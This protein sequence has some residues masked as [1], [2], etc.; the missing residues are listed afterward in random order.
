MNQVSEQNRAGIFDGGQHSFEEDIPQTLIDTGT[1]ILVEGG[2]FNFPEWVQ[3]DKKIYT[4]SGKNLDV[5][6]QIFEIIGEQWDEKVTH[7]KSGDIII[8]IRSAFD[9]EVRTYTGTIIQII[10]AVNE[11]CGCKHVESGATMTNHETGTT[12]QMADGGMVAPNGKKSNLNE[13]Q[14]HLVRT[15]EFKKWFG[16]WENDPKNASKVVDENGE[17]LVVYHGISNLDKKFYLF[18]KKKIGTRWA[19]TSGVK[20]F[21]FSSNYL[22]ALTYAKSFKKELI[23]TC[24]LSIKNPSIYNANGR[25]WKQVKILKEPIQHTY[26]SNKKEDWVVHKNMFYTEAIPNPNF[27]KW[28]IWNK[29]TGHIL[30][31]YE[32]ESEAIS[33]FERIKKESPKKLLVREIGYSGGKYLDTNE[34]AEI[35]IREGND[36]MI[37]YNVVDYGSSIPQN[38]N[39]PFTLCAVFEPTQIKLADG[40]N[41]TFDQNNPDI[42]KVD[43]GQ[44][45]ELNSDG[46]YEYKDKEEKTAN[47]VGLITLPKNI[48]TTNCANCIFFKNNF[49][50]HEKIL[51]PV[52]SRM[53]CAL[54]DS[55]S[56]GSIISNLPSADFSPSKELKEKKY[57]LNDN[58]GFDYIGSGLKRAKKVDLITLPKN[59][60]GT[61]CAIGNCKYT[62]ENNFC[63][64]PK[65]MLPVTD[66]MSCSLWDNDEAMRSWKGGATEIFFEDGKVK[67]DWKATP[68]MKQQ[69]M[70]VGG[71]TTRS[72]VKGG[73]IAQGYIIAPYSKLKGI[74]GE[75]NVKNEKEKIGWY[76]AIDKNHIGAVWTEADK[77]VKTIMKEKYHKWFVWGANDESQRRLYEVLRSQ[78]RDID[79]EK[80]KVKD[81]AISIKRWIK[82]REHIQEISNNVHRLRLNIS[83][84]LNSDDERT[85]LIALI[86]AIMDKTAER[87]GNIKSAGKGHFGVT[88]FTKKHVEV[89]GNKIL[90]DYVG[91]TGVPH[92]KD[93]S[94]K[95]IA[96]A[97]KKAIKN[98]PNKIEGEPNDF[99]F[100]TSDGQKIN[101]KMV[102]DFLH[103]YQITS[104]AIRGYFANRNIIK[105]LESIPILE[106]DKE[107]KKIFNKALNETAKLVQHGRSTLKTHY[108]IPELM[109]EY[110]QR[111]KIIDMKK[112]GYYDKGGEAGMEEVTKHGSASLTTRMADGAQPEKKYFYV[113][114]E[115]EAEKKS[116]VFVPATSYF[117][118]ENKVPDVVNKEA[119][120]LVDYSNEKDINIHDVY[121]SFPLR[122][123]SFK[124]VVPMQDDLNAEKLENFINETASDTAIFPPAFAIEHE[125][126]YYL[127]DGHHRTVAFHINGKP[128][129]VHVDEIKEE[130]IR[131]KAEGGILDKENFNSEIKK[132]IGKKFIHNGKEYKIVD[133]QTGYG[134]PTLSIMDSEGNDF[135]HKEQSFEGRTIEK[136]FTVT[137]LRDLLNS[138]IEGGKIQNFTQFAVE[139]GYPSDFDTLFEAQ[140]LG[141]RGLEGK[142]QSTRS[143]TEQD[144]IFHEMLRKNKQAHEEYREAIARGEIIDPEGKITAQGMIDSEKKF[145]LDKIRSE[146]GI[147][148]NQ[149][150]FIESLG[151]MAHTSSGKLKKGY[152]RTVDDYAQ[153]KIKL[154]QEQEEVSKMNNGGQV[155]SFEEFSAD[156]DA[157]KQEVIDDMQLAIDKLKLKYDKLNQTSYYADEMAKA[158][159]M[160][161]VGFESKRLT[162]LR[163]RDLERTID[164]AVTSIQIKKDIQMLEN[165]MKAYKAGKVHAN[166]NPKVPSLEKLNGLI[167]SGEKMLESGEMKGQKMTQEEISH[168]EDI[169]SE[170]KKKRRDKEKKH[171]ALYEEYLKEQSKQLSTGGETNLGIGDYTNLG[172][173]EDEV[174]TQF[175]INGQWYHKSLVQPKKIS[176]KEKNKIDIERVINKLTRERGEGEIELYHGTD[177]DSYNK[178]ISDKQIGVGEG[179]TF[180]THS[181]KEAKEYADNKARYRNKPSGKVL[182]ITMPK[183]AVQKNKATGEYETEFE[184]QEKD[185]IWIP[186][187][188][189]IEQEYLKDNLAN[190]GITENTKT[191]DYTIG[192]AMAQYQINDLNI[193][194][195]FK[196]MIVKGFHNKFDIEKF[197]KEGSQKAHTIIFPK[198]W[199]TDKFL[200]KFKGSLLDTNSD[201]YTIDIPTNEY[202]RI[203]ELSSDLINKMKPLNIKL[204][205][206]GLTEEKQKEAERLAKEFMAGLSAE[207]LT[208]L[209]QEFTQ[210]L[211]RV[212]IE[213]EKTLTD[214]QQKKTDL[215]NERTELYAKEKTLE[216]GKEKDDSFRRRMQIS[217]EIEMLINPELIHQEN[218]VKAIKNGGDMASFTDKKG[219]KHDKIPSFVKIKTDLITF[220]Q[221]T[222]LT[223]AVPP[224]IPFINEQVFKGKGFVFDAIRIASDEYLVAV[225]GYKEKRRSGYDYRAGDFTGHPE[226]A[227]QGYILTT[228]DQ[229]ALINDYYFTKEKATLQKEADEKNIRYEQSYDRIPVERRIKYLVYGNLPVSEKKKITKED[230]EKLSVEEKEK[231]YKPF[232]RAGVKRLKSKLEENQMWVSYHNMYER[233]INPEAVSPKQGYANEE[234]FAYW[235]K[236]RQ[237]MEWKIKD[238]KVQR[239]A[240]S[241][242]RKIALETSF[243]ESNTNDSLK[244]KYGILVKRQNGTKIMPAEIDQ[245][246][247]AW[248]KLNKTFGNLVNNAKQV[249]LK[250]SH[251]GLKYVFASKAG[252]M[253]LPDMKTIAV[254]NKFGDDQ[255][256]EIFAHETAHWIDYSI[257]QLKGKRYATDD[258]ESTA[259]IIADTLRHE[260]NEPSDSDYVNATKECFARAMEQYFAFENFGEDATLIYSG[261]ALDEYRTY[262]SEDKYVS[263]EVFNSKLKPLIQ[264]FLAE[265]E[266]WFNYGIEPEV[267]M[268]NG[269]GTPK[270]IL[271]MP[272]DGRIAFIK[273]IMVKN[274]DE[275]EK[276][277]EK[278]GT[279]D[280]MSEKANDF[281][282][283]YLRF[284]R[285]N[286]IITKCGD[287]VFFEPDTGKIKQWGY[288]KAQGIYSI[289]FIRYKPQGQIE[290]F[291]DEH[292]TDA[293]ELIMPALLD[294]D[295]KIIQ[296]DGRG[297]ILYIKKIKLKNICCLILRI[298]LNSDGSLRMVTLMPDRQL[299][300][301]EKKKASGFWSDAP[302]PSLAT[303]KSPSDSVVSGT[304]GDIDD[305]RTQYEDTNNNDTDK[306]KMKQGG[307]PM[308]YAGIYS[309]NGEIYGIIKATDETAEYISFGKGLVPVY[310]DTGYVK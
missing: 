173:I 243:G 154:L 128:I 225:N 124:D 219:T 279:F 94:D 271:D 133:Y 218:I 177:I 227:E 114:E 155:M 280:L 163:D 85:F 160:G 221:E 257:G 150:K 135:L 169:L 210:A 309:K 64:H 58:G 270:T 189:S 232:Q 65:I 123:I 174:S 200:N 27:N 304:N 136:K 179:V 134:S 10:S 295:M 46:G 236:F 288:I 59:L 268:T 233:F 184:L 287:K 254:T 286:P 182:K 183:W 272:K 73:Q 282:E 266:S 145:R 294:T 37:V 203:K 162:K 253:F 168:L 131:Q 138:Y 264:K 244:E 211:D 82:K 112:I 214:I 25:L 290:S 92:E 262:H 81:K 237:M 22:S 217:Q 308:V 301:I 242:I 310:F 6:K 296:H 34:L 175:K 51:L 125:G 56:L 28:E 161:R 42:R 241:E 74:L 100:V 32:T 220:D 157:P 67:I 165:R 303:E 77:S 207:E 249:N 197:K 164:N 5:I 93:F 252:G 24:F 256:E 255:F 39:I 215:D 297:T 231:I 278:K 29:I 185:G 96:K 305:S 137:S 49:C 14:W 116:P 199:I 7:V 26:I 1:N 106:T 186:T 261:T 291:Y 143:I 97:L 8:C 247:K 87:I 209:K 148:D 117:F 275:F 63:T 293:L 83:R 153:K 72:H 205:N 30:G 139:K 251:T 20:A 273:D 250:I 226:D 149:I 171:K 307:Q 52:T 90:L 146:I 48:D 141:A 68:E 191:I 4:L 122:E 84:D 281:A 158:F 89:I 277:T 223:D 35:T 55:K 196:P 120:R 111:G 208:K 9:D 47:K 172:K 276:Y 263:K 108:M 38:K 80:Q 258:F 299:K 274:E 187:N 119:E 201:V 31:V 13:I 115:T 204:S 16:E 292:K 245:I 102:N 298:E 113:G 88:C 235:R 54:W 198:E 159:P 41:K 118:N 246:R 75:P 44:L 12:V 2:E 121:R 167:A 105:K 222:I 127:P 15:P 45:P 18:D 91:K 285:Q 103:P 132:P 300:D 302:C 306:P 126:K 180:F 283:K 181:A 17:P 170:S 193:V 284:N 21:W 129:L 19:S 188:K 98:S 224:Y 40:S 23:H 192:N 166:G 202:V 43:G 101:C 53:C 216:Y 36:G 109:D 238:I 267:K 78:V 57:P 60:T 230:Y 240:E 152:Q 234:V 70:K 130:G 62:D 147:I 260:M 195:L 66:K 104:K 50:D 289:H 176:P 151:K 265:N 79:P 229:L 144:K 239:E 228:L 259:G 69:V 142:R 110:V 86:V 99:I 61:N 95:R 107:R 269:G 190:G 71:F 178:I 156:L 33:E 11:S 194:Y 212:I 248:E 76:M 206:G 140:L 3:T 213:E